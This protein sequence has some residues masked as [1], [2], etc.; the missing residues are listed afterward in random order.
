MTSST[1]PF[2]IPTAY[3]VD[4]YH[5]GVAGHMPLGS[6]RDILREME[7][8][9]GWKVS[10]EIEPFSWDPLRRR[11]PDA[12]R[13]LQQALQDQSPQGRLEI[14]SGSYAQ[15]YCWAI[16]G[17]SNIRQ[18]LY[19]LAL[20][21]EHFPGVII[22]TYAVQEPCWTSA[23]PQILRSLGYVRASLK[24]PSTAW[25]GYTV[26]RDADVVH[27]VGPDG[28]SIPAVP[29][30]ACEELMECWRTE[31]IT[32]TSDFVQKCVANGITSPTGMAYQDAGW[33]AHP[34][35]DAEGRYVRPYTENLH[36]VVWATDPA[37]SHIRH[38]T[39]REYFETVAP[40]PATD[41]HFS[42]EDIRVGLPWGAA[43]LQ[44][45][46]RQVRSAENRILAAE[47]MAALAT[48]AGVGQWPQPQL[49]E[50]WRELMFA[51]HHDIWIVS[52]SREERE[53]WAWLA[54]KVGSLNA[55]VERSLPQRARRWL[56]VRAKL[57]Q[58]L[59]IK[60]GCASSTR[61]VGRAPIWSSCH[62]R[63]TQAHRESRSSIHL[64]NRRRA[65]L[66]SNG[67]TPMVRGMLAN[68]SFPL[69]FPAWD[70]PPIGL[71]RSIPHP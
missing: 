52:L 63:S 41:W 17:E 37:A 24:N 48:M 13:R 60:S 27:W 64:G 61:S 19:G 57:R 28:T 3:Y 25:G 68:C 9:P 2:S 12:Y 69:K 21:Q 49:E 18:L 35:V 56:Q 36:D 71:S 32:L 65:S 8:K 6:I 62:F 16:G 33:P 34:A 43:V 70:M 26:G 14:V 67:A 20:N 58:R 10:L 46:A 7:R 51:Q 42:Q 53:N 31:S 1:N 55:T 29:R 22:D 4:G 11:D 40:E 47:K 5:G 23:L 59:W 54:P 45:L 50:A 15:P 44:R 39:W 66:S 38:V 30:Y